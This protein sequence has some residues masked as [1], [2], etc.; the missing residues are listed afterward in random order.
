MW[1]LAKRMLF[2]WNWALGN[3]PRAL[4]SSLELFHFFLT[5]FVFKSIVAPFPRIFLPECKEVHHATLL[6]P[7]QL[8]QGSLGPSDGRSTGPARHCPHAHRKT[9]RKAALG[10]LRVRSVRRHRHH[11]DAR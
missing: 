10:V 11:R 5:P 2:D 6:P 7:S 8:H 4:T 9:R 1:A 3:A